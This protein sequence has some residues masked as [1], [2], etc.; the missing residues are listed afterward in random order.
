[1]CAIFLGDEPEALVRALEDRFPRAEL[2][3]GD[4]AFDALVARVVALVDG[5]DGPELPLDLRGTA[6]QRR[7]WDA[8][9]RIPAGK[10]S[11]YA[12]I[13]AAI[14]EPTSSR[15]VAQACGANPVA[16]VVPCHRVVR[17]DGGIS[18]Y[19]WGVDRKRALLARESP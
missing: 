17:S 15:A 11:T 16:V 14:G 8:L 7:V 4:P 19:R 12:E 5:R 1:M 2:T 3:G 13:A 9:R 18:G 6:F 10:T